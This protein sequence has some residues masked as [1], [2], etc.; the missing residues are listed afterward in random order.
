MSDQAAIVV[1]GLG[2]RYRLGLARGRHDTMIDLIAA[3]T[4][5]L[6]RGSKEREEAN[7]QEHFWALRDANFTINRGENVGIIGLNGA[8]KST[9][10][11][12]LSRITYPTEGSAEIN[13]RLG[14]LLEVGTGFHPELTGRENIFLYGA[15]LGMSKAEIVRKFDSIVEFAEIPK[16]IDTP[17]KRYSSG[18]YVRLAF[19]VA[20]HLDPE[21]LLLDEVL[22]VGDLPFQ[23]KCMEFAKSLQAKDATILFVSHNMFSI[24]NMCERVIYLKKG[25]IQ[26]DGSVEEGIARY[27][28]DGQLGKLSWGRKD[29]PENWP[30]FLER[31]E[32]LDEQGAERAVFDFGERVRM[33]LHFEV[34]ESLRNPNV[35]VLFERSDGVACCNFSSVADG[36]SLDGVS[37][38][39]VAVE[40]LTPPLKLVSELYSIQVIV[41]ENGYQDVL[42]A[43]MASSFHVRHE[44]YDMHFGV[45]HE[46]GTWARGKGQAVPV[47]KERLY[48]AQ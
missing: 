12:M 11:K 35:I 21:I 27:E 4:R 45:F 3:R 7:G 10:L 48:E 15:I 19:S 41:R 39:T 37:G 22:A 33:R 47:V 13:G 46:S 1:K 30:I 38:G 18:M 5:D 6:F 14:A 2:K 29:A 17:V 36:L 44:L 40:L 20:A 43:Q 9:L 8:G 24:K 31:F 42:C 16:F 26:Y 34:R 32:L 28:K 25:Q 23:R